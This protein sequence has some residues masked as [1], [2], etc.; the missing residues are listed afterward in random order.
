MK[1]LA[2]HNK[3]F[4][5]H[6]HSFLWQPNILWLHVI[7][8][9]TIA[10]SYLAIALALLYL[11]YKRKD[12]KYK[13]FFILFAAFI[14]SC[15]FTHAIAI[16]TVWVPSYI[17]E[18]VIKAV[19]AVISATTAV[20]L[21]WNVP[22]T[23]KLPSYHQLET[24]VSDR[25]KDSERLA[26]IV[27]HSHDAIISESPDGIIR[28][29]NKGAEK[30]FQYAADEIIGQSIFKLIPPEGHEE[31]HKT[32]KQVGSGVDLP[33]Y[34]TTRLRKD[35][36]AVHV[37]VTVSPIRDTSGKVIAISSIKRDLA[38]MKRMDAQLKRITDELK[39]SNR[40]L[41][42]MNKAKD[43][44]IANLSHELR[45]PLNII[46]GY[47]DLIDKF[48]SNSPEHQNA[49][50][51]I[52]RS[53][54][55]QLHMIEDLLDMSRILVGKFSLLIGTHNLDDIVDNAIKSVEF[56]ARSKDVSIVRNI[57]TDGKT[58]VCDA[59][60]MQQVLWNLL[61][62]AVKWTNRQ[63]R[64][65]VRAT[66][67]GGYFV[68]EVIDDGRGINID[69]LP[70]LFDR[71]WQAESP[72]GQKGGLGLG[73]K[74]SKD[75]VEAH[76]GYI[77]AHSEGLDKGATFKVYIPIE[78][79]MPD[80]ISDKPILTLPLSG[81]NVLVVDDSPDAVELIRIV[82]TNAGATVVTAANGAEALEYIARNHIQFIISD[83]NMPI[84]D[85]Y[86]FMER[87][88]IIEDQKGNN[89]HRPAIALTART[90]PG[91]KER[92]YKSGYQLHLIKP[93]QPKILVENV[94]EVLKKTPGN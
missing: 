39:E 49:I 32:L 7:S 79:V 52:K 64:I 3:N 94:L 15:G 37:S 19:T 73:L 66:R 1:T 93:V 68:F 72:S 58:I 84:M 47:S 81:L 43:E 71:L 83:I 26:A 42:N 51:V 80:G 61:S 40:Q 34:E 31:A 4:L 63:G 88:R 33:P 45:S 82:L 75:L 65:E 25:V 13:S 30:L 36:T 21:W 41:A 60:R 62:N 12:I 91:E 27:N 89:K 67:S 56:A 14:L 23:L 69:D 8:D 28:T 18:G 17:L 74:I 87:T 70:H 9:A 92:A 29:W 5:P 6:G 55:T 78:A 35:G 38:Q 54:K 50:D 20:V 86:L 16:Y 24:L 22:L 2:L 44:F 11:M 90:G 10:I 77:S 48:P 46:L 59:D 76:G 85:G 57:S 53:A